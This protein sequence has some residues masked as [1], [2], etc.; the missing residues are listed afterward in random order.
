MTKAKTKLT[1]ILWYKKTI[2]WDRRYKDL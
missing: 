2:S 1:K